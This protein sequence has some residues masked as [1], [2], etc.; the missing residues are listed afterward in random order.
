MIVGFVVAAVAASAVVTFGM[1]PE[2]ASSARLFVSS[3][4][5]DPAAAYE[6]SLFSQQRVASYA[7]LATGEQL[8]RR[9][10]EQRNLDMTPADLAKKIQAHVVPDTVILEISVTDS[11][12][13]RAQRLTQG[14]AD[15]LKTFVAEIETPPAGATT[16]I[17]ATIVDS[18]S[19]PETPVSP[20]PVRNLGVAAVLGLLLGFGVAVLTELLDT[21]LKS[22][23]DVAR[24]TGNA[25][26][27]TITFDPGAV[28]HPLV[29]DL[30]TRAPRVEAFRV[31]RTNL[32][33]VDVDRD[34]KVF[35][36][37]SSVPAEGKTT[38]A[39]NLAITLAQAGQ[40]VLLLEGD[41]RRPRIAE[42]LNLEG[43]VGLTTVLVGRIELDDAIQEHATPNL[44]VLT[45]GA[46]PPN[47]S[48]LLQSHAMMDVLK[49]LRDRYDL[50]IIDA[51]PLLPVTDA[52]LLTAES[53]RALLV[54]RH[55]RTTRD[56]LRH[57]MDRL[58]GV[59]GRALGVVLNMTPGAGAGGF[60][61]GGEYKHGYGEPPKARRVEEDQEPLVPQGEVRTPALWQQGPSGG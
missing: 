13:Q 43:T 5:N 30:G 22:N 48:E 10:I 60:G 42:Y 3:A 18:A 47:P 34:S 23:S 7:T 16:P 49:D 31:L 55:G 33:F 17:K 19:L 4:Q 28:K 36:V 21:T 53:D 46:V 39:L 37:T 6:S 44:S 41:L 52:A 61:Y 58:R 9:V 14:V 38:T 56:Q 54:V 40:K 57:A 45:S 2:Y 20:D 1:T 24:V 29:T 25:V 35:V 32:Q 8:A 11:T 26:M 15:E 51:P 12:P 27:G 59:D 50:V